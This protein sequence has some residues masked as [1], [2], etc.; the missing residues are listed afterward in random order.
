[1]LDGASH[2]LAFLGALFGQPTIPLGMDSF[3]Q[4]GTRADLYG[5]A[6]I[7]AAHIVNAVLLGL[8]G[9]SSIG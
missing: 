3:G 5:Y 1:V 6:G 2:T 4:S 7:D 8:E 9:G